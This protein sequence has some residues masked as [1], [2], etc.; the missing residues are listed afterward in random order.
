MG[1]GVKAKRSLITGRSPVL[2]DRIAPSSF[3]NDLSL[4]SSN[5]GRVNP[6]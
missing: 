6:E 5:V 2:V 4:M 1:D 3:V